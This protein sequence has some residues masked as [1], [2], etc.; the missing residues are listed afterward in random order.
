MNTIIASRLIVGLEVHVELATRTKMFS[1]AASPA[2][3]GASAYA[4]NELLDPVVAGLPG[5]LPTINDHAVDLALAVGMALNCAIAHRTRFDRKSYFYPDMPK[6]YQISQYDRPLCGPGWVNL[7]DLGCP[8]AEAPE[9]RVRITRAHLEEDAGKLLHEAPGGGPLDFSIVDLNRAGTP[10]LEIVT[11]PDFR[12]ADEAVAFCRWVRSVC[13]YLGASAGVLQKGHIRFEPNINCELTLADG[14][15]L[16]TPVVEVKNLNSFKAVAGAIAFEAADQPRRWQH[17]GR[18]MG[19]GAKSTRGW[20]GDAGRTTPQRDKEDAHDYRYF[21]DPD[22]PVLRI[23]DAR[24]A[25]VR[26]SLPELPAARAARYQRE[27]GLPAA[28]ARALAS[29]RALADSFEQSIAAAGAAGV[30]REAAARLCVNLI[31]QSGGKRVNARPATPDGD[32]DGDGPALWS[33]GIS[34]AQVGALGALRHEGAISAQAADELFGLLCEPEHAGA[35]ARALATER[36]MVMV[37]D[38][39]AVGA[40]VERAIAENAQAAADVRAGKDAALGRLVGAAM[41]LA[42]GRGDAPAIRTELLRHLR[43]PA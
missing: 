2:A 43:P 37:K 34:A 28:D 38:A 6:A 13:V 32:D 26:A 5:A 27:L 18:A 20:D 19:R 36:G 22:L 31:V 17:D 42:A 24:Q 15:S 4:P 7:A 40:W 33:L 21:P 10:L 41:K 35:D 1:G 29:Q 16:R 25:R 30:P 14:R 9:R 3:V 11:E 39:A 12:T 23:D 8:D